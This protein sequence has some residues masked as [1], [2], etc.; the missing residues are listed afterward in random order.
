MNMEFGSDS[1]RGRGQTSI[2][3]T[4]KDAWEGGRVGVLPNHRQHHHHQRGAFCS[5]NHKFRFKIA[6]V[7]LTE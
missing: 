7:S 5:P 4:L 3:T 2:A 6:P 1:D